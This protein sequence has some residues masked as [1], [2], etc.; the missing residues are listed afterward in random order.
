MKMCDSSTPN[1]ITA[2]LGRIPDNTL[3]LDIEAT[4]RKL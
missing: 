2:G 1:N 3:K 4:Q